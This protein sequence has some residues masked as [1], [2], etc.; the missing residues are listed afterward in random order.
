MTLNLE[1]LDLG[2]VGSPIDLN[3][4]TIS[5]ASLFQTR[6]LVTG[7]RHDRNVCS[8]PPA[9]KKVDPCTPVRYYC[10]YVFG[11]RAL[12]LVKIVEPRMLCSVA[13][14]E[15]SRQ[16]SENFQISPTAAGPQL[17]FL[18]TQITSSM[19]FSSLHTQPTLSYYGPR[20]SLL[21]H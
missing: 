6:K 2:G 18:G 13:R 8:M 4:L 19:L 3:I 16:L 17:E 20:N 15:L 9:P 1:D 14:L 5:D 10:L 7:T 11:P 12:I 21:L